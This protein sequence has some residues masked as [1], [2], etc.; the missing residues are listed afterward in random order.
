M[1][2]TY[3]INNSR[4]LKLLRINMVSMQCDEHDQLKV[5]GTWKN[6]F[7]YN[8]KVLLDSTINIIIIA[9]VMHESTF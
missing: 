3:I 7:Y 9:V 8:L 4:G 6:C 1:F 2:V 5:F